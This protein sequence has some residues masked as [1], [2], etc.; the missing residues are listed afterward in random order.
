ML[1]LPLPRFTDCH[2][3]GEL[4]EHGHDGNDVDLFACL[5]GF[6]FLYFCCWVLLVSGALHLERGSDKVA[7]QTNNAKLRGRSPFKLR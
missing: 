5:S 7:A 2:N 4:V 1:F 3:R 6:F